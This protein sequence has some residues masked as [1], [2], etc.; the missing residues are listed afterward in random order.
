MNEVSKFKTFLRK[1]SLGKY[2]TKLYYGDR[3]GEYSTV[4]GGIITVSI[5]LLLIVVSLNILIQTFKR[6][7]YTTNTSY[8]DLVDSNDNLATRLTMKDFRSTLLD[9]RYVIP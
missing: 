8:N 4:T 3:T 1:I 2:H 7:S 6:A 5:G 9:F